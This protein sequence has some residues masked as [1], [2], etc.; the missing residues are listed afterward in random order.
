MTN[1]SVYWQ[2]WFLIFTVS[3]PSREADLRH[4]NL[5]KYHEEKEPWC[6]EHPRDKSTVF[7]GTPR[8]LCY[9]GS[10]S[11]DAGFLEKVAWDQCRNHVAESMLFCVKGK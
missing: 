6:L 1:C 11:G 5:T 3:Q 7:L 4:R 2:F 10:C 9:A 8:V